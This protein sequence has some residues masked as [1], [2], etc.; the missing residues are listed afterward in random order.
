MSLA[1]AFAGADADF[2]SRVMHSTWGH[3]APEPRR[4]YPGVIVFAFSAYGDIVPIT[5]DF[6]GLDDSPWFFDHMQE[7]IG[8]KALVRGTIYRF[9]GTYLMFKNGNGRFSGKVR[10]VKPVV[11]GRC[12][13]K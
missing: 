6:K 10:T 2:K 7:F 9:D 13:A 5:S 11:R 1:D 3:L 8:K 4:V 12:R